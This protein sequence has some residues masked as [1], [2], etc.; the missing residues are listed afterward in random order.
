M[1]SVDESPL[2][3]QARSVRAVAGSDQR[4]DRGRCTEESAAV[5]RP[6]IG[7]V[8][9]TCLPRKTCCLCEVRTAAS[10]HLSFESVCSFQLSST[11]LGEIE[12]LA[13]LAAVNGVSP[14]AEAQR[15]FAQEGRSGCGAGRL[16]KP[17]GAVACV[18][19]VA[20]RKKYLEA[21]RDR[22][23]PAIC[24]LKEKKEKNETLD[25]A[26]CNGCDASLS[27]SCTHSGTTV[28]EY[29]VPN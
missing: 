16:E 5:V 17:V 27:S 1:S 9:R 2:T 10:L 3:G 14:S 28:D 18:A 8:R 13:G 26:T 7:C 6:G 15:R 19:L 12:P 25:L 23:R 4:I 20:S 21:G 29:A 11:A 24:W 22:R